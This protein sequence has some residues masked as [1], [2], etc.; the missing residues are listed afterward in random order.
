MIVL[1]QGTKALH[2]PFFFF[3]FKACLLL[4]LYTAFYPEI[5]HCK[6]D[7]QILGRFTGRYMIVLVK[8]KFIGLG[9]LVPFLH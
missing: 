8:E 3:K 4:L 9:S 5:Y 1:I 7:K 6:T 2:L